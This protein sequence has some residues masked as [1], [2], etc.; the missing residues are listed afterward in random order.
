MLRG[1][2]VPLESGCVVQ[3]NA[4]AFAIQAAEAVLRFCVAQLRC[5]STA[6]SI[7]LRGRCLVDGHAVSVVVSAPEVILRLRVSLIRRFAEPRNCRRMVV[8]VR[9]QESY[10]ILCVGVA[11]LCC[12]ST[13]SLNHSAAA[14]LSTGTP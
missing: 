14:A 7:P 1:P 11:S 6:F 8:S 12:V 2:A 10:G 13:A 4:F 9:T 5:V 3:R